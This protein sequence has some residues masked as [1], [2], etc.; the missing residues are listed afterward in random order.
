MSNQPP[1][2]QAPGAMP[3]QIGPRPGKGLVRRL[4]WLPIPLFLAALAALRAA[5]P[6]TPYESPDLLLALNLFF[7][8]LVCAF[9]AYLVGRSFL[10]RS[11][12]GL[13]LLGCGVVIWGAA[14]FVGVVAGLIAAGGGFDSNVVVTVHNSCV[15]LSG[16]CHL[17]GVA[18]S[19]RPR[20]ALGPV[21]TWLAGGYLLALGVVALVFVVTLAGRMPTFFVQ[22]QGGTPLRYLVLGSALGMFALTGLLLHAADR[23]SPSAFAHWYS[24]ALGM[25]AVGIFGIMIESVHGGVVSWTGRAP[26]LLSG[27]Y[28]LAAAIA[29]ARETHAWRIPLEAAL[30][31]ERDLSEVILSTV[32]ALV[33][34]LDPEGRVV[35]F[36]RAC[37]Q[38]TGYRLEEVRGRPVWDFLIL[39]E[40]RRA[41]EET[42]AELQRGI[43][44]ERENHWVGKD[45]SRYL[46]HWSNTVLTGAAGRVEYVIC[47]GADITE[48]RQAE[49]ALR[50]TE[51]ELREAQRLARLGNWYWDLATDAV[52]VSEQT[53]RMLGLDPALSIPELR[54][55]EWQLY[56]PESAARV[57]AAVQEAIRSGAGYTLDVE[58]RREDG[59]PLWLTAR[60]EAVRGADGRVVALRGTN[61]DITERKQAEQGQERLQGQ[62]LAA[63]RARAEI[64]EHLGD[65][66]AHRVKNNLAMVSG[67]LQ[68]QMLGETDPRT[69]GALREAVGRIRTFVA[70]HEQMYDSHT[71]EADLLLA[72]QWI[73]SATRALFAERG[74][75]DIQVDGEPFQCSARVATN[76]SVIANEL[77]TNAL[78][79]GGPDRDGRHRVAVSLQRAGEAPMLSVWNSGAPVS[80]DLDPARARTMGL[81]LVYDLVV[82]QYQ[83]R[84]RLSPFD[85]G[86]LAEVVV[87]GEAI[88]AESLS[89]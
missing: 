50:E 76:L 31:R 25:I 48:R 57:R 45:G 28:L 85:G 13:L 3:D 86:T 42:F 87:P 26:Q 21:G 15:W 66:V 19:R 71:E 68:M 61:Q 2:R 72:L 49:E 11:V 65:E 4:A 1:Q 56:T 58:A 29:S 37:E 83:G 14:G 5:D 6:R 73:G 16:L 17:T 84:F 67:L 10:A 39:P 47:A 34:V 27:V 30:R 75:I 35:R 24:I 80:V 22:G 51:A 88:H 55:R 77:I 46:T 43:V 81:R 54:E 20:R 41:V 40:E 18:L 7:S 62:L 8:V 38:L 52:T 79:H 89:R 12:P 33:V 36:N 70:L 9:I 74:D 44:N 32:G 82:E 69:A 53:Y 78:K 60:A 63:E 23:R 59:T 64:A